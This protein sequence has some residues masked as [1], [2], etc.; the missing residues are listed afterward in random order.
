MT[1]SGYTGTIVRWQKMLN[2]GSWE[3]IANTSTVYS[4]IPDSAG[5]WQYRVVVKSGS[6]PDAYSG[7]FTVTVNQTTLTITANDQSKT[8]GSAFTFTGTEFTVTGLANG[9]AVT[10]VTLTSAGAPATA[11]VA[12]SPYPITPGAAVGTGLSNYTIVYKNGSFTVNKAVLT[13]TA[14]S[15]TKV[16]GTPNPALTV[17]YSG[18]ENGENVSALSTVPEANTSVTDTTSAGVYTGAITVSGG[19]AGNYSFNYVPGDFT[20][21]KADQL[22][23]FGALALV[24]YGDPD[25][26]P[27][28]TASSGLTVS[29]SS[30]N[31]SVATIVGGKTHIIGVGNAVIT[32]SQAGN[33][34]Y[35]AAPDVQQTLSVNKASQTITFSSLPVKTYGDPDF[36][37]G[38]AASSG[39]SVSYSSDNPSV[40]AITGGMIHLT[41]SGSADIT[42]SQAGN[43]DYNAAADVSQSLTVNKAILTFT[44]DDKTKEYLTANPVLTYT[45]T[46]FVNGDTQSVLD[47]LPTLKTT[48]VQDSPVGT[49]PVTVSGGGDNSYSYSFVDGTLTVTKITQII[50]FTRVPDKLLEKDTFQLAAVSLAGL[51]VLFES[52]DNSI[53]TINGDILTGVSKGAVTIKAYNDGNDDYQAADTSAVVQIY[54]THRD[55]MYLFTPNGDGINDYWEL[56]KLSEWGKCDVKVY[57]RWGKLVFSDPNYNNLWNGTSNGSPLPEGPYYF[58]IKTEN[59]GIITGTVNI[60]R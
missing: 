10:S 54:S 40:A 12:G 16:Y 29:Y 6:C 47:S 36:S 23:T 53:A 46:G 60:V 13:V 14:D 34:D 8:Y 43:A 11:G 39:L 15:K 26:D 38:A 45:I 18:W 28:A 48:C 49:Y 55:I 58:I 17:S 27:G 25:F 56:P 57:N 33:S 35:N 50:T 52:T 41:G 42:A 31:L 9:D 51:D 21:T 59:A 2:S 20:V 30:G 3:D 19:A 7:T 24:A 22:I 5:T 1:L 44:A 4:E 32:A 37:P